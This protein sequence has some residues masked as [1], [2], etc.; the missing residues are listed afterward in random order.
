MHKV[1]RWIINYCLDNNIQNIIIGKNH[2]WKRGSK[3]NNIS[4]QRFIQIPHDSLINKIKYKAEEKGIRIIEVD[5]KYT[6]KASF[7]DNDELPDKIGEY[8]F[9]GKRI[10]RGLYKSKD[11][12]LINA[13][14]N[15]SYNILRKGNPGFKY[16]DR[17]KDVSLH[18]IR[19]NI[20]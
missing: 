18:P 20:V 1:S 13:D 16:D 3:M 17:I 12:I 2:D 19:L 6:S 8:Q 5:E 11:G 14:V 9:S 4:N 7:I 10:Y 15:G